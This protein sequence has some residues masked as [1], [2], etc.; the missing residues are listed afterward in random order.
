MA[1][2][3]GFSDSCDLA[4]ASGKCAT[5]C[6][7]AGGTASQPANVNWNGPSARPVKSIAAPD[8]AKTRACHNG[9]NALM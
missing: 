4:A 5:N 3:G 9:P 1:Q 2:R 8:S 7:I 6:L